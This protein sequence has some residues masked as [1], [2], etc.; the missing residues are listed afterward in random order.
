MK[1]SYQTIIKLVVLSF[2]LL[3]LIAC[4]KDTVTPISGASSSG[5]P[6]QTMQAGKDQTSAKAVA[7][8]TSTKKASDKATNQ[9]TSSSG[10][11]E[12]KKTETSSQA[13]LKK[14]ASKPSSNDKKETVTQSSTSQTSSTST[15]RAV[16][17]PASSSVSKPKT[18]ESTTKNKSTASNASKEDTSGSEKSPTDTSH[19]QQVT[20]SIIG[21]ENHVIVGPTKVTINNGDTF[22]S[23]TLRLLK[24][25]GIQSS[26]RGTGASAYVEGIDNLYEFDHGPKSGWVAKLNQQSLT[27]SAGITA[28]K[29]GDVLQWVYTT[30]EE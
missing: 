29:S 17:T 6:K 9:S 23:V 1:V 3:S 19:S 2:L 24:T 28:I 18:T 13:P 5:E 4:Q 12:K 25:K 16:S 11:P 8:Q 30:T 20:I 15:K 7:G 27:K 14:E 21:Y 26:V 10:T 22:L